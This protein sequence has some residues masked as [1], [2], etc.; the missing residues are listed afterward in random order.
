MAPIKTFELKFE[1]ERP[2]SQGVARLGQRNGVPV[3]AQSVSMRPMWN[4]D[5]RGCSDPLRAGD[6]RI[7][8]HISFR[9]KPILLCTSRCAAE[10]SRV[11]ASAIALGIRDLLRLLLGFGGSESYRAPSKFGRDSGTPNPIS[12]DRGRF[13]LDG[14]GL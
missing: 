8:E 7:F 6:A 3:A 10:S 11:L 5:H 14:Y 13:E 2:V 1:P 12:Y 4:R 9:N